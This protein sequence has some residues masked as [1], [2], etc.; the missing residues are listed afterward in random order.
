MG[1]GGSHKPTGFSYLHLN[2]SSNDA[3]E[4]LFQGGLIVCGIAAGTLVVG[5]SVFL[6]GTLDTWAKSN[7]PANYAT[8]NGI[9]VGGS[10]TGMNVTQDDAT[11]G[12]QQAATVG[13]QVLV[14]VYG[15]AKALADA[16]MA[17]NHVKVTGATTTAGRVYTTGAAAGTYLGILLNV[18]AGAASV[19]RVFVGAAH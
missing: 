9:V 14:M 13:Q 10:G 4:N 18:A 15:I 7:T 1:K 2:E 8:V 16:A 17:T 5:D 19:V 12:S 11:I 6:N 3:P